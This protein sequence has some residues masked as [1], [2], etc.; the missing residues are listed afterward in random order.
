MRGHKGL[1]A[2]L[3]WLL[4]HPSLLL[5]GFPKTTYRL[6][7]EAFKLHVVHGDL[8]RL[9]PALHDTHAVLAVREGLR[10]K[11]VAR[12]PRWLGQT[13]E[14]QAPEPWMSNPVKRL[15]WSG[16]D[17]TPQLA[18]TMLELAKQPYN[19]AHPSI[20]PM[21]VNH[22]ETVSHGTASLG[23]VMRADGVLRQFATD[24]GQSADGVNRRVLGRG[25]PHGPRDDAHQFQFL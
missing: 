16:E 25:R 12:C 15:K 21:Q 23:E 22:I 6:L 1:T 20:K 17:A 18:K 8:I 9:A 2:Y 13:L 11:V 3:Q 5:G 7:G 24:D 19:N 4:D 14:L 10:Q